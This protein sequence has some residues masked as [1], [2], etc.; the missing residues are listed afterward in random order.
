MVFMDFED[1]EPGDLVFIGTVQGGQPGDPDADAD[2]SF[3]F[4][5]SGIMFLRPCTDAEAAN[6]VALTGASGPAIQPA[7]WGGSNGSVTPGNV[8]PVSGF[9]IYQWDEHVWMVTKPTS[10]RNSALLASV[11]P[12][13]A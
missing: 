8:P 11:I 1:A 3:L 7:F 12:P 10:R 13:L 2:Q 9:Q 6:A 5:S 4:S